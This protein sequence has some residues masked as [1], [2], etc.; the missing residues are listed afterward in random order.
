MTLYD[1]SKCAGYCCAYPIIP[2]KQKDTARIAAHFKVSL[3]EAKE[4]YTTPDG[5][6]GRSLKHRWDKKLETDACIFLNQSSRMCTIYKSRPEICREHPGDRCEWYDRSLIEK[7]GN[8][9]RKVVLLKVMPWTIDAD[10][11][12]YTES[13]MPDLLQ[14]YSRGNRKGKFR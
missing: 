9:G 3:K 7:I 6:G 4:K 8:G 2:V 10:Y 12:D 11:P 14:S 13:D 5:E 1:C